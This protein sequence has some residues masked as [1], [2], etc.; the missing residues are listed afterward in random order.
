RA[1]AATFSARP[2]TRLGTDPDR[3]AILASPRRNPPRRCRDRS[4]RRVAFPRRRGAGSAAP[5]FVG[6]DGPGA[7]ASA[8]AG[9]AGLR[10]HP[11]N[12]AGKGFL[13]I[14]RPLGPRDAPF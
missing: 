10:S 12:R 8:R 14:P 9:A 11:R 4:R 13:L 7:L 3:M 2:K 5:F 1:G 6:R